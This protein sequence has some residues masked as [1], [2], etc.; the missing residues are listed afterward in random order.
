MI[1][2]LISNTDSIS[3]RQWED[4]SV[5][6]TKGCLCKDLKWEYNVKYSYVYTSATCTE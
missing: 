4:R 5:E 3:N 2:A 6:V 1:N